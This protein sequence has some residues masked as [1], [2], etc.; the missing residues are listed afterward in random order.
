[1]IYLL[2]ST[3]SLLHLRAIL[4][5]SPLSL[6]LACIISKSSCRMERRSSVC[7][8]KVRSTCMTISIFY[9]VLFF[10][11]PPS[12]S[13]LLCYISV[14]F[15]IPFCNTLIYR[16]R[17]RSGCTTAPVVVDW[18]F[19]S[20]CMWCY[21]W[22]DRYPLCSCYPPLPHLRSLSLFSMLSLTS[23]IVFFDF[24]YSTAWCFHLIGHSHTRIPV[25]SQT[26]TRLI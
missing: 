25:P 2:L 4:T 20:C 5:P 22:I 18:P 21:Q 19:D 24:I 11:F 3:P 23:Y 6:N 16:K 10:L 15:L 14:V 1:M 8:R 7:T 13:V 12:S 17:A 9:S 26:E